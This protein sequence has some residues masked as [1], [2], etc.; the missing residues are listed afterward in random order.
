M[1]RF[2]LVHH[3][4]ES[5]FEERSTAHREGYKCSPGPSL[6][7]MQILSRLATNQFR[8]FIYRLELTYNLIMRHPTSI[9]TI[10]SQ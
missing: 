6:L 7:T 2:G 1:A 3:N 8:L 4:R 5:E 10:S 9:L